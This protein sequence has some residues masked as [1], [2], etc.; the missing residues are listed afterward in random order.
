MENL[1]LNLMSQAN[2]SEEELRDKSEPNAEFKEK[3][4]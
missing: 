3:F 4:S 2:A 1:I